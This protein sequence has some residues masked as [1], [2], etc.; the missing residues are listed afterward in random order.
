MSFPL[1]NFTLVQKRTGCTSHEVRE[2]HL[3]K[4][5]ILL[6]EKLVGHPLPLFPQ[7]VNIHRF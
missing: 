2:N 7:S 4:K 1:Y 5:N 3:K 6:V